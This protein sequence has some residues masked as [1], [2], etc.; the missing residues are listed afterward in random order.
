VF[1]TPYLRLIDSIYSQ[2]SRSN[3][4]RLLCP[5]K[6]ITLLSKRPRTPAEFASRFP[7]PLAAQCATLAVGDAV[8]SQA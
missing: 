6:A 3:A 4:K 7:A 1:D 8:A 2:N 5:L